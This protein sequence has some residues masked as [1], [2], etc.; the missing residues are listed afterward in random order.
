VESPYDYVRDGPA[1]ARVREA[2]GEIL[3]AAAARL[4]ERGPDRV[5][6]SRDGGACR[7]SRARDA[8]GITPDIV[9]VRADG[10]MLGAP[11]RFESVAA[12]MWAQEW[13]GFCV[14]GAYQVMFLPISDYKMPE[15]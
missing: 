12:R 14:L 5:V 3:D 1:P 10:W 15:H 4:L 6:V 8:H 13:V 11:A 9:F 2:C 7:A